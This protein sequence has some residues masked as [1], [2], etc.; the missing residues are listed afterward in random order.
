MVIPAHLCLAVLN[1]Q[2]CIEFVCD[3]VCARPGASPL[4]GRL[5]VGEI[6]AGST[7]V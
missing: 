7:P 5:V 2:K 4:P 3:F 6:I 1:A